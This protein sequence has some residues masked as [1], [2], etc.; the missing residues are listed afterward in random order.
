MWLKRA[1]K[2]KGLCPLA[3]HLV[4]EPT[5][6]ARGHSP[7][8]HTAKR[9]LQQIGS[10]ADSAS[11]LVYRTTH[12]TTSCKSHQP[13]FWIISDNRND[14]SGV[15]HGPSSLSRRASRKAPQETYA[16]SRAQTITACMPRMCGQKRNYC[17]LRL[18]LYDC[19]SFSHNA[20][21]LGVAPKTKTWLHFSILAS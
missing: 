17:V 18:L 7:S 5:Q 14:T 16:M 8:G 9:A 10:G 6:Q 12:Y 21:L 1:I 20:G 15:W 3:Q 13:L 2:K 11:G 4:A 19:F